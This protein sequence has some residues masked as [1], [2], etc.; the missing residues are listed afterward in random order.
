SATFHEL[1]PVTLGGA[2]QTISA[3][4]ADHDDAQLLDIPDGSPV[5]VA[6]RVTCDT[7]GRPVLVSQ[8]VYP[9]HLTEFVVDL[10]TT[11]ASL[12]PAGLR[13]VN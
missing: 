7:S 11:S 8:H 10:P 5:L 1:M 13:L 2:T 4:A 9:G 12:S 3:M 6:Q